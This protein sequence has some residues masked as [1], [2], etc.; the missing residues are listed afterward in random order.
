MNYLESLF[1]QELY[2]AQKQDKLFASSTSA[3]LGFSDKKKIKEKKKKREKLFEVSV[4]DLASS[5]QN[6]LQMS[7]I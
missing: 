2:N 1:H 3:Y 7:S 6:I 5:L 4:L